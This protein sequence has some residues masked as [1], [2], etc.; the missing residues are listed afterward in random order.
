MTKKLTPTMKAIAEYLKQ[1]RD[2]RECKL[3]RET[4]ESLGGIRPTPESP[5]EQ[6]F[7]FQDPDCFVTAGREWEEIKP[8]YW[9][10]EKNGVIDDTQVFILMPDEKAW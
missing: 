5:L 2:P 7:M 1:V 10:P 8:I 3:C 9:R 4:L 6:A